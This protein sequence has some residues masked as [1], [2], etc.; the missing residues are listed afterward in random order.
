MGRKK[1]RLIERKIDKIKKID[2]YK[3]RWIKKYPPIHLPLYPLIFLFIKLYSHIFP[4]I[5]LSIHLSVHP[6]VFLSIF[7]YGRIP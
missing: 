4:H 1:E 7:S 3:E 6:F 2:G 5:Y